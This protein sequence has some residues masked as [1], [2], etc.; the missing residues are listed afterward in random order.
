MKYIS[1]LEIWL[2]YWKG[3]NF[4]DTHAH[5]HTSKFIDIKPKSEPH[6]HTKL[7]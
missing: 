2:F 5:T 4:T 6:A 3:Q 1:Q 7:G